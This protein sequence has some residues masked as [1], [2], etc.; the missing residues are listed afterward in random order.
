MTATAT[1]DTSLPQD[2]L[3]AKYGK[4]LVDIIAGRQ[5]SIYTSNYPPTCRICGKEFR[6]RGRSNGN[7]FALSSH[8]MMHVRKGEAYSKYGRHPGISGAVLMPVEADIKQEF[9]RRKAIIASQGEVEA[10][11][12]AL[13]PLKMR[14]TNAQVRR[15]RYESELRA[16]IRQS[17]GI[18]V[19]DEEMPVRLDAIRDAH[20]EALTV[21]AEITKL[22]DEAP[23]IVRDQLR[24]GDL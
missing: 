10:L 4:A 1:K 3:T 21:Q 14:R 12:I 5:E 16:D 22:L 6:T 19:Y 11:R 18:L 9:E 20:A 24:M 23:K 13:I 8:A 15:E 2:V 17:G 7:N